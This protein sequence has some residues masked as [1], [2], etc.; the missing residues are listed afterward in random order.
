MSASPP[1]LMAATPTL[2]ATTFLFSGAIVDYTIPATGAYQIV[3]FGAQGGSSTGGGLRSEASGGKGA[4]PQ[5]I[6][7]SRQVRSC[8]LWSG[9]PQVTNGYAAGGRRSFV[10]GPKN[11]PLVIAGGGGRRRRWRP[12]QHTHLRAGTGVGG[13]AQSRRWRRRRRFG[14]R[15]R[16][17]RQRRQRRELA[18]ASG[19]AAGAVCFAAAPAPTA[20]PGERV[21]FWALRARGAAAPAALAALAA[22]AAAAVA[23]LGGGGPGYI[24]AAAKEHL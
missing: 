7:S 22:E 14:F 23:P 21:D 20:A 10:I 16:N 5:G 17:R 13:G 18:A 9:A 19:A 11:K 8:K 12:Y 24:G 2:A 1:A 15:E 6:S 3:A 4:G